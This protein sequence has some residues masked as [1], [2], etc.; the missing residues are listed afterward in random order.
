MKL[1]TFPESLKRGVGR[2]I[3]GFFILAGLLPV[4]FTAG[5]AYNEMG[6]G[7]QQDVNKT[8]RVNAKNYG[9]DVFTR[10]Q[11]AAEAADE[12]VGIIERGS[13]ADIANHPY[14]LND[15]EAIW[16]IGDVAGPQVVH[17]TQGSD[18]DLDGLVAHEP[19]PQLTTG[20][21]DN[22]GE[23]VLLRGLAKGAPQELLLAFKPEPKWLWGADED[24]PYATDICV[25]PVA[26]NALHC[27]QEMASDLYSSL[28]N[29]AGRSSQV[30]FKWQSDGDDQ[31]AAIW[32]LFLAGEFGAQG[33][34]H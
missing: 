26:G 33:T 20:Y 31:L 2:R 34:A 22:G 32:Q 30:P 12:I 10:L 16:R 23:L 7:L 25:F 24:L 19:L 29:E 13:V 4:I 14:L 21:G 11:H 3:L 8:L 5:F 28:A 9:M 6:R 15:F 17:G 18:I 27:S 1:P